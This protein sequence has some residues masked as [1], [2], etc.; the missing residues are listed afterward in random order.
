MRSPAFSYKAAAFA[1]ALTASAAVATPSHAIVFDFASGSG[2]QTATTPADAN[3]VGNTRTFT[4]GTYS[5]TVSA[6]ALSGAGSTFEAA[7]LGRY[8]TGLGV[9]GRTELPNCGNPAHQADNDGPDEYILFLFNKPV[10]PTIVRIDPYGTY[11][12][13]V[14]YWTGN[15]GVVSLAGL[16]TGGLGGLGFGSRTDNDSTASDSPR[17]VPITSGFVNG[18]LFGPKLSQGDDRF[19]L[20]SMTVTPAP[21]PAALAIFGAGLL[22]LFAT[23]RRRRG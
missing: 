6:W 9:C 20:K 17:D 13:D 16:T 15:V 3:G 14:S 7:N 18:M 21:E 11:D 19:K 12:R 22:G 5:V 1:A 8:S 10:D 4:V 23:A 2:Q